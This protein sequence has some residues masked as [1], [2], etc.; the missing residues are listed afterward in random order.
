MNFLRGQA[1]ELDS[2]TGHVDAVP[3]GVALVGG[4]RE[5]QEVGNVVQDTIDST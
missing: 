2:K 4:V 3:G 1:F 5:L